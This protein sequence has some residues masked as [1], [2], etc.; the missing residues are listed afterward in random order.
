MYA[1]RGKD[2]A[3]RSG[4]CRTSRLRRVPLAAA[5]LALLG[6]G[7]L[8]GA[9]ASAGAAAPT[10]G[11]GAGLGRP[12]VTAPHGPITAV[13]PTFKWSKVSGAAKYELRVYSHSSLLLEKTGITKLSWKSNE[14][15]PMNVSLTSKVRAS[16]ARGAGAW[17]KSL[18]F[19]IGA[20]NSTDY[21]RPA[22]WLSVPAEPRMKV[23]VFYLYPT[24][25]TK[26]DPSAPIIG[27]I[28][29]P[30]MMKGAGVALQRQAWAFRTFANI[31]APYYRQADAASR[32]ALPQKEQVKIVAGAPTQDGIAAFDYY[33]R[34]FNHGRPFILAGH[35]LGS[36]VMA[37]LLAQY[38]KARPGVYKRMIAAYVIGYSITPHYLAQHPF[39]KFAKGPSDTGVIVSWNTE[40]PTVDGTNPVLLPG[41]LAINPITWTRTE[42]EATAAQNLGSIELNPATGGTPVLD[43]N[44]KIARVMNLAD[45]RI[46]KAKGVVICSTVNPANPPYFTPGGLPMGVF[47]IFDYPFYFFDVRANAAERVDHF[48]SK[49]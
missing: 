19:K 23:D 37:N 49:Q 28:D 10:A 4:G 43:E 14:A 32:A 5:L 2:L 11:E 44:G 21:A 24:A 47:H 30:G 26:A 16:D 31:Y 1:L 17:S 15:L 22:H 27:P 38:M 39:L 46:D 48:L 42:T 3:Q 34:H 41:G 7:C 13:K 33:I 8:F 45:A 20:A 18:G 35:S 25:Y 9:A 6:L 36:N 40:A 12:T 29:D